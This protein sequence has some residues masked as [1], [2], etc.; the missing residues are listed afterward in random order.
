[1]VVV[2]HKA[3]RPIKFD[4]GQLACEHFGDAVDSPA[5]QQGEQNYVDPVSAIHLASLLQI[6]IGILCSR[7]KKKR[8][9]YVTDLGPNLV[10]QSNFDTPLFLR[11]T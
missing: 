8:S 4:G 10:R 2:Q 1:M 3:E 6:P 7:L 5:A 9:I 11:S